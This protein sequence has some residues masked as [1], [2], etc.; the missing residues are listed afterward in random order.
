MF[1]LRR[2]VPRD[3]RNIRFADTENTVSVCHANVYIHFSWTHRDELALKTRA[4]SATACAADQ[5]VDVI[6]RAVDDERSASHFADNTSEVGEKID[7]NF[8]R[9]QWLAIFGAEDQVKD[10][11][12]SGM[13][14]VSFAPSELAAFSARY[15]WLA[16]WA[17]FLRRIAAMGRIPMTECLRKVGWEEIPS[18][19]SSRHE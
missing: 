9:D 18:R 8:G 12:A 1:F 2:D 5:H 7:A 15:P 6:G 14:H 4:I 16:P 11:I 13:G 3:G 17:A 19:V 10:E